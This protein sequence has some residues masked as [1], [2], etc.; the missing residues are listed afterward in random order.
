MTNSG[1]DQ[2][3]VPPVSGAKIRLA[4]K[5]VTLG[6][7][8]FGLSIV[9]F[10]IHDLVSER[11]QRRAGV[12]REIAAKWGAAQALTGP[13]LVLPYR[14]TVKLPPDKDGKVQEQV[15]T[16]LLH[17]LP[18]ALTVAAAMRD[19][20]R[21][22]GIYEA[23]VYDADM[24][25]RGSIAPP[26]LARIGIEPGDINWQDAYLAI[27]MTDLRGI[28]GKLALTLAGTALPLE[29]GARSRYSRTGMHEPLSGARALF[30]PGAAGSGRGSGGDAGG[31]RTPVDFALDFTISGTGGLRIA[32]VGRKTEVEITSTWP[33][34]QFTGGYLPTSRE[35]SAD[36]FSARWLVNH[37]GRNYP[38]Y[39]YGASDTNRNLE[40][41]I[42]ASRFG[43][44]L[45]TPVDLYHK[46]ER[47]VKYGTL[48]ILLIFGT[49]F[50]LE[51]GLPLR[52]SVVEYGLSGAALALFYLMVLSLAEV[53]GFGLAYGAASLIATVMVTAYLART[54]GSRLLLLL[55][56]GVQLGVYGYLYVVLQLADLALLAG[57]AGLVVTLA[58]LMAVSRKI[59]WNRLDFISSTR[60]GSGNGGRPRDQGPKPAPSPA[61]A[62]AARSARGLDGGVLGQ[63]AGSPAGPGGTPD[64]SGK[65]QP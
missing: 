13:L 1:P 11:A 25:I 40:Q 61:Q 65:D 17:V 33:H 16:R 5:V 62:Q 10:L 26:D 27:G 34:P 46:T 37:V 45:Y 24:T 3:A 55:V 19:S 21:H 29:P 23:V 41:A 18:E 20:I 42:H 35:I 15:V 58:I 53:I 6:G 49:L 51:L 39:W 36:G 4:G 38:Q 47:T 50:I 59:D 22:I 9:L 8:I 57:T 28:R 54:L 32:P 14:D 64:A 48:F 56:G 63:A 2:P 7:I 43:V 12:V 30:G 60:G 31:A 52:I 44:T